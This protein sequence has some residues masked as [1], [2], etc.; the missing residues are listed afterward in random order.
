MSQKLA[1]RNSAAHQKRLGRILFYLCLIRSLEELKNANFCERDQEFSKHREEQ[2]TNALNKLFR[3]SN[4]GNCI[5]V[6]NSIFNIELMGFGTFQIP[7][8]Y[9]GSIYMGT[10]PVETN[11]IVWAN[12]GMQYTNVGSK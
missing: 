5:N 4:G 2:I 6:V 11:V 10:F 1:A 3:A 9:V 8:G 12:G 7:A